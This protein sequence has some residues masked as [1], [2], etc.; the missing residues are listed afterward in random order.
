M[1]DQF[2]EER[3]VGRSLLWSILPNNWNQQNLKK[4]KCEALNS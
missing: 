3:N 1:M 2:V 4:S